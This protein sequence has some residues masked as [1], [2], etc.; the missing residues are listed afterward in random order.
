M[1]D[2]IDGSEQVP[3][4]L[5]GQLLPIREVSRLTGVN[6]VTLRAWERRYGLIQPVRTE[7]GHRLYSHGNIDEVRL[8]LG[9]I[10]RGVS[11]SKVGGI[12]A[13]T[14]ALREAEAQG[15]RAVIGELRVCCDRLCR[16]LSS[17]DERRLDQVFDEVLAT[18][19]LLNAFEDVF[20]PVWRQLRIEQQGFGQQSEWLLLDQYLR[21]RLWQRLQQGRRAER[22]GRVLLAAVPGECHELELLLAG[23]AMGSA[24]VEV[25]VLPVRQPVDELS[26]VCERLGPK[27]MVLFSN[28]PPAA[29][30]GQRMMKLA[31]GL[32]CPLLIAGDCSD[33]A[34]NE[35]LGSAVGCMGSDLRAYEQRLQQFI[36]GRLDT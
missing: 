30:F 11:V 28:H 21:G 17:F 23:L 14:Q 22:A 1:N 13:R 27:A 16:A 10:E 25:Q 4:H 35:L 34:R 31:L 19:P 8:I 15:Q 26:L 6:P 12:L 3:E 7:S 36:Q 18:Y 2:P 32:E 5:A 33:L 24:H 29:D 20:M 9:W